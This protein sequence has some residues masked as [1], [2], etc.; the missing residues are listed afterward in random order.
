M[1]S[2]RASA[3]EAIAT[4]GMEVLATIALDDVASPDLAVACALLHDTVEDTETTTDEIAT[5]FGVAVADGRPPRRRRRS[6]S[7]YLR[8]YTSRWFASR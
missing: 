7:R 5:A 8:R 6:R 2:Q 1:S 3:R 4:I